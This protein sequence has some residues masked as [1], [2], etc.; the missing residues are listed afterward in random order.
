ME[1]SRVGFNMTVADRELLE[2]GLHHV[3]SWGSTTRT[4]S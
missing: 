1:E 3:I 4:T 2:A